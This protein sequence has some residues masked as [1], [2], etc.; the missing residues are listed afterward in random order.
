MQLDAETWLQGD[1]ELGER[2]ERMFQRA[3]ETAPWAMAIGADSPGF[4][5]DAIIDAERR[6]RSIDVVFGPADDG[7]FYFVAMRSCPSERLPACAGAGLTL[8]GRPCGACGAGPDDGPG[9]ALVRR[10]HPGG[11]APARSADQQRPRHGSRNGARARE[12][13]VCGRHERLPMKIS[14][15]IPTLREAH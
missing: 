14:A 11:S 10:G 1:G 7:G 12:A 15:I 13:R 3:L 5:L 8:C 9:T 6:L 4:P 2:L